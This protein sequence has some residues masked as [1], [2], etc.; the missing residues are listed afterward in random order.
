MTN[1][2]DYRRLKYVRYADDFVLG[3]VGPR[4]EAEEIKQQ[5]RRFLREELKLELSEEKTLITHA[6][7][8]AARFLGYEI[9]VL[10]DDTKRTKRRDTG[11]MCRSINR[12][13][14]LRVPEDVLKAKID[15]YREN[16]E[17]THRTELIKASDYTI[18]LTYQLEFRGIANYYQLA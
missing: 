14:G 11:R 1:D 10:Q 8:E 12:V 3:F 7:S 18:V 6:V 16:G 9:T 13:I 17:A 15:R 4:S 5:L 2:P